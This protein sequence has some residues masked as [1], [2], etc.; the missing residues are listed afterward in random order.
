METNETRVCSVCGK[1]MPIS[2]FGIHHA[3]NGATHIFKMCKS[4]RTERIK[5]GNPKRVE[6][7]KKKVEEQRKMRLQDFTPRELMEE[8]ARRGY[9]GSLTYTRV[10]TIDIT[11]F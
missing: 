1:E 3:P 4:C 2:E 6:T 5:K 7:F 8:L 9:K 10:E 11:D